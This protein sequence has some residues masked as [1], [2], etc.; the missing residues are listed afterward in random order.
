[1][2]E[3]ADRPGVGASPRVVALAIA[4]AATDRRPRI[5]YAVP[6]GA[7]ALLALRRLMT[8]RAFDWAIMRAYG[9]R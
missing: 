5:R 7:K 4:R 3:L 1:V 8:D 9:P 6:F 2:Y